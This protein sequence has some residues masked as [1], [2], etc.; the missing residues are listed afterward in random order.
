MRHALTLLVILGLA[1]GC[2][3]APTQPGMAQLPA[4]ARNAGSSATVQGRTLQF[5]PALWRDFMP[6]SPPEGQP[7]AAALRLKA[8]GGDL[9]ADVEIT[10]CWVI[11]GRDVWR[12]APE[13]VA[14]GAQELSAS[15][16]GGP[17]WGPGAKVDVVI[18]VTPH[19]A[20]PVYL[21][22]N[23]VNIGRTD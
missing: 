4:A 15:T 10:T 18:E 9:P 11:N 16:R 6:I 13:L 22:S 21:A 12:T 3:S 7:L 17:R 2:S 5:E 19:G 20:P 1:S 14:R 23:G 8:V